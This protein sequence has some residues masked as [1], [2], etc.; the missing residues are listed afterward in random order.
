MNANKLT[1]LAAT[2]LTMAT[3]AAGG[4]VHVA[5]PK[6]KRAVVRLEKMGLVKV[7]R[8]TTKIAGM[9]EWYYTAVA[10]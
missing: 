7:R 8:T 6:E 5:W 4:E 2:M 10:S 9:T 3:N 1:G